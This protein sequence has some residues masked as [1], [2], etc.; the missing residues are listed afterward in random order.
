MVLTAA[1]ALASCDQ[2]TPACTGGGG[3][4]TIPP[5]L[6]GDLKSTHPPITGTATPTVT[7]YLATPASNAG[8]QT[9]T[10]SAYRFKTVIPPGWRLETVLDNTSL[11]TGGGDC[12]YDAVYFPPVDTLAL[13]PRVT[14]G[15]H[16]FMLITVTLK[17]PAPSPSQNQYL[18]PIG[19]V[20]ISGVSTMLYS[21]DSY[22][23]VYRVAYPQFGG[24][25]YAFYL[26]GMSEQHTAITADVSLYL[27]VL[28][29]FVYL[30]AQ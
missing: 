22:E 19:T 20:S 21:N 17:C 14:V 6:P 28:S 15:M 26:T 7:P 30:G 10:D 13:E 29:G 11:G 5:T 1:L 25:R 8:W 23:Q 27:G 24:H 2:S 4:A 18:T 16:E 3:Q 12:E 9:Y